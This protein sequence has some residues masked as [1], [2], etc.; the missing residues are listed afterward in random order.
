MHWVRSCCARTRLRCVRPRKG[1]LRKKKQPIL[2]RSASSLTPGPN[3]VE[4]CHRR[5]TPPYPSVRCA[6]FLPE[7]LDWTYRAGALHCFLCLT[8][9]LEPVHD[10]ICDSLPIYSHIVR[11]FRGCR[12]VHLPSL[13]SPTHPW[14]GLR[15]GTSYCSPAYSRQTGPTEALA[16]SPPKTSRCSKKENYF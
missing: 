11:W 5:F 16:S 8:A 13:T 6:L 1:A 14:R 12:R 3:Y 7:S 10:H 4:H 15:L 2:P 9:S